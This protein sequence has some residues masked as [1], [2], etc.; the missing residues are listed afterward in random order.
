MTMPSN[1]FFEKLLHKVVFGGSCG[2]GAYVAYICYEV[3]KQQPA[4][5]ITTLGQWGALPVVMVIGMYFGNARVSEFVGVMRDNTKAQQELAGA[6]KQIA[7][8]DDRAMEEHRTM[9]AYVG[10]QMGKILTQQEEILSKI[11]RGKAQGAS[12]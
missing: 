8:K 1:P 10:Q 7:E 6:V 4:L 11:D 12:A 9:V 2:V 5:A 3:L